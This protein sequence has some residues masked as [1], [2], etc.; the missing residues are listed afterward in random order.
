M[1]LFRKAENMFREMRR[2]KQLLS[3]KEAEE[4]LKSG[5][6]GVLALIGDEGYPY[7]VPLSYVY[8]NGMI[9]F[10]SAKSGHKLDAIRGCNKASFCV[11]AKDDVMPYEY[12]T[13]YKSV[14]A[15]GRMHVIEDKEG[16]I[17]ALSLLGEKY[18]PGHPDACSVEINKFLDNVCVLCLEIEH[19]TGKAATELINRP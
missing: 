10:H 18:N 7:S 4:I 5:T 2:K 16:L 13:Y 8:D 11:I 19:M 12:T 3:Q 14:I 1:V 17:S 9:Y 6:A 15:F